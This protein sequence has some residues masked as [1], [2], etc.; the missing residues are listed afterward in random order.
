MME[1][2]T[3][4]IPCYEIMC[5][6]KRRRYIHKVMNDWERKR[7][8][9]NERLVYYAPP[10]PVLTPPARNKASAARPTP[11]PRSTST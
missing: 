7:N 4:F 6:I 2:V 9:G 10:S 8:R 11:D 5:M 1:A 3:I